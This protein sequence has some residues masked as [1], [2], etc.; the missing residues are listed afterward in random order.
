MLHP[1]AVNPATVRPAHVPVAEQTRDGLVESVHYGSVI[2]LAAD[3]GMLFSAGDPL[4]LFYPRS[5]LKPLQAVAMVRAGLRLPAELLALSAASHSGSPMHIDG[6][7][8]ILDLHGLDEEALENT[9]TCPTAASRAASGCAAAVRPAGWRR[10]ARA[11][12]RP[13]WP[14]APSTAGPGAG[15]WTRP[16]PCSRRSPASSATSPARNCPT[17]STTAAEPRCSR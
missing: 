9:P 13:C 5:S 11:N 14:P 6:A 16:T 12:T 3:G 17:V 8:R 10:T 4:A 2:A 7:R 15:T 1:L